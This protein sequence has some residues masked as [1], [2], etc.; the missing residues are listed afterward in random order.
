VAN[1]VI[2]IGNTAVKAAWSDG[3]VLGK[4]FRY[5][6]EKAMNFIVSLIEKERP[7]VLIV[8]SVYGISRKDEKEL[9]EYCGKLL[10]LDNSNTQI[11]AD[12]TLPDYITYDRAASIIA[13]RYLFK[14]KGCTVFDFGTTLTVDFIENKGQ[15]SGGNIS[16]GCRTRFKALNRYSK[17]LPLVNTPDSIEEEGHSIQKSIESGV[18]SGIMFEIE[19]YTRLRPENVI[20]FTGGDAVYFAK[21][22]KNSIFVICNLVLM[23]LALIADEYVQKNLR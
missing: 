2:E 6:G 9:S 15:Y 13:A 16:L 12:Y 8:A 11:L 7:S 20:V 10:I 4:T 14:G 3:I 23:G 5:Q 21:R 18:I 22:M 17:A 1:L 19:G